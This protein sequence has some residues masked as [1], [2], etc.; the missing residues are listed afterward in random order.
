M[1]EITESSRVPFGRK[2]D[3]DRPLNKCSDAFLRWIV[4]HMLNTDFHQWAFHAGNIL[5]ERERTG[6]RFAK[7]GNLDAQADEILQ[8]AGYRK[9]ARRH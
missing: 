5:A 9:L 2:P 6:R 4:E 1:N 7:E 3:K 8:R